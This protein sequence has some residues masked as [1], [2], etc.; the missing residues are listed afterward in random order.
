MGGTEVPPTHGPRPLHAIDPDWKR[1]WRA[2]TVQASGPSPQVRGRH[3]LSCGFVGPGGCFIQLLR[4]GEDHPVQVDKLS[5]STVSP[6]IFP[7][8]VPESAPANPE[9]NGAEAVT[10]GHP[11]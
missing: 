3:F 6:R 10:R 7:A 5:S 4:G 11:S 9:T 8:R 1:G 2:E